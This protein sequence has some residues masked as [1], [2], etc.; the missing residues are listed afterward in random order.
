MSPSRT[1][2][3]PTRTSPSTRSPRRT[4]ASPART[5]GRATWPST[6]RNLPPHGGRR[7]TRGPATGWASARP[8]STAAWFRACGSASSSASTGDARVRTRSTTRRAGT[9]RPTSF[10]PST[11]STISVRMACSTPSYWTTATTTTS[12][13]SGR[14]SPSQPTRRRWATS[15]SAWSTCLKRKPSTSSFR[16]SSFA[17]ASR[18]GPTRARSGR[19]SR[20]K[21]GG[22]SCKTRCSRSDRATSLRSCATSSSGK[23]RS[24]PTARSTTP[25]TSRSTPGGSR[26]TRR[27]RRRTSRSGGTTIASASSSASFPSLGESRAARRSCF[28]STA[29]RPSTPRRRRPRTRRPRRS[30]KRSF[31]GS[32]PHA[33]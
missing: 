6:S 25:R 19:S 23:I 27:N 5:S 22:A 10:T 4:K 24:R 20:R 2:A 21:G 26:A 7:G 11:T 16:R 3:S 31:R 9:A 32:S 13:R 14:W 33:T 15:S 30:G 18:G 28:S 8:C 12:H 29:P 1:T 17:S